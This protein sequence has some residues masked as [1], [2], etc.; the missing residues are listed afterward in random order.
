MTIIG[1]TGGIGSGKS[2]VCTELKE[3]HGFLHYNADLRV[4]ELYNSNKLLFESIKKQ[5]P[6]CI[7]Y[8]QIILEKLKNIVFYNSEQLSI[9]TEIVNPH[10]TYDFN[11]WKTIYSTP[12]KIMLL[13]SAVLNKSNLKTS[14]NFILFVYADEKIRIKRVTERDQRTPEEI[15]NIFKFQDTIETFVSNSD[16]II[17]NSY[18]KDY[19]TQNI[20]KFAKL[21]KTQ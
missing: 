11:I 17:N 13:E 21:F 1:V 12:N 10:I 6:S 16:F 14:C 18:N 9:L 7:E 15:N 8:N 5:F 3:K 20:N 19:L 4:K 2:T